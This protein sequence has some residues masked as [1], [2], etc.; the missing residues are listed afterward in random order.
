MRATIP[1][2]FSIRRA[3][4]SLATAVLTACSS[5]SSAVPAEIVSAS[6]DSPTSAPITTGNYMA[7]GKSVK[8]AL[9]FA[10]ATGTALTVVRNTGIGFIQGEFDNL[11]DG[12]HVAL[13][14]R[15]TNYEFVA[16]Y[17]GG[18]GNDLVL[19]WANTRLVA[20]GYNLC[21]QLGENTTNTSLLPVAVDDSARSATH[22]KTV[23]AIAG[24]DHW[25]LALCSDGTVAAWGENSLGQLGDGTTTRRR[26]PT[27]VSTSSLSALAG[28][29]VVAIA[30]GMEHGLALCSDGSVAAW[31]WNEYGQ[32][33]EGSTSVRRIPVLVST[34]TG[35]A[36]AGK[37]AVAI[38]A[39]AFHNIVLCSDGTLATWGL[40]SD[41][42]LGTGTT[43]RSLIPVA[44]NATPGASALSGRPVVAISARGFR[45]LA[46]C[47]DGTLVA[48]GE[49]IWG[50]LGDNSYSGRLLAVQVNTNPGTSALFEKSVTA[51]A[52]GS[53]HSVAL[54][55]DGTITAWGGNEFGQIGD[56]E[57][58]NRR[59]P[60]NVSSARG[61]SA[62]AGKIPTGIAVGGWHSFALLADGTVAAWGG[63][64][65]GELGDGT[66]TNRNTPVLV[67]M[68]PL[69]PG[70][71][72]TM[73]AG[74]T[75]H[76]LALVASPSF[77]EKNG[78][79]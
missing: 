13:T 25:S 16:N 67:S 54:C 23:I 60:V 45:N 46:L 50:A 64:N 57:R 51:I 19:A 3:A 34:G 44:V 20:W 36:L 6:L 28:R 77:P 70:E 21:G 58:L 30:A 33:G 72:F 14:Y 69:A 41:G 5:V 74:G 43:N 71:R 65:Y 18:N 78:K 76:T 42:Q 2:H 53:L 37:T 47:S 27:A 49:N 9:H 38:A 40:N 62:L 26:I 48:W 59:S 79:P 32:L 1:D 68:T 4:L 22:G 52:A 75:L 7:A 31:G 61:T 8:L 17:H 66:R 39:G 35:S 12:Q 24:G 55:S 10:P 15:G 11:I 73:V 63:N 56:G 29:R